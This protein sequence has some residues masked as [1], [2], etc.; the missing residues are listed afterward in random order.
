[1]DG[2]WQL[3]HR[4]AAAYAQLAGETARAMRHFDERLELVACG[5]S[6]RMPNVWHLEETVLSAC[7]DLVDYIS[8]HA[9]YEEQDGD[10]GELLGFGRQHGPLHRRGRCHRRPDRCREKA[11]SRS[12]CRSTS[13]MSGAER[14]FHARPRRRRVGQ[15]R[16]ESSRTPTTSPTP[17][18]S[19]AVSSRSFAR[20]IASVLPARLSWSSHSANW[21][22]PQGP[23]GARQ[24]FF[25]S[26]HFPVGRGERSVLV[27]AGEQFRTTSC[28]PKG[29]CRWSM[30]YH[31]FRPRAASW[32]YSP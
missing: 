16:H 31:Q 28:S 9:Y 26:P 29:G 19:G 20:A 23:P 18:W 12:C 15:W 25:L 1:M 5:S 2:P 11:P 13:G 8:L 3:G 4:S 21:A 30:R 17:W 7:Y 10:L 14:Q 24:P 6:H 22:E 32:P 27:G